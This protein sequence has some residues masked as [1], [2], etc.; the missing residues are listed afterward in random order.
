MPKL[1]DKG[2]ESATQIILAYINRMSDP[3]LLFENTEN[4]PRSF[5]SIWNRIATT[6]RSKLNRN[7][8]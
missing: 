5:E 8:N 7:G 4:E 6:R 2:I 1:S 3:R